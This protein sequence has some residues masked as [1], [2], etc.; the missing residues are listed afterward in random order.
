MKVVINVS[1][2]GFSLSREAVKMLI[3]LVKDKRLKGRLQKSLKEAE[4]T[5]GGS[6]Y[7]DISR[8]HPALVK[9]VEELGDRAGGRFSKLRV[10]EIPDDVEWKI[11]EYDGVEW[12]TEK[13]RRWW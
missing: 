7:P 11:E 1:H 9:V 12:V 4:K 10:V 2:G 6:V 8:T 3:T 13:K 5:W